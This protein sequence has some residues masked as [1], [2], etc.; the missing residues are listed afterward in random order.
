[1]AIDQLKRPCTIVLH[2]NRVSQEDVL[3][4]A[5]VLPTGFLAFLTATGAQR[6]CLIAKTAASNPDEVSIHVS[7]AQPFGFENR[8]KGAIEVVEDYDRATAAH[9]ELSFRDE[10]LSRAD[11]WRIMQRLDGTVLHKGQRVKY[12]GSTAAAVEAIYIAEKE[13]ASAYATQARTKPIFRS[14]SARY[15]ILLQV[16]K[17]M[18]EDWIDG[19]LMYERVLTGFLPELFRR[20][21]A[22]KVRHQVSLVLFGRSIAGVEQNATKYMDFYQ[23]IAADIP[24]ARWPELVR[25]LKRT[26]NGDRLPRQVSLAAQGNMLEAMH[27]TI[28]DYANGDVDPHLNSTGASVIAVTA[29]A[30]LFETDHHLLKATTHLLMGNSI[31]VDIVALSPKPLHPVPLFSYKRHDKPEFALPHW[32]DISYWEPSRCPAYQSKWILP[33]TMASLD[34]VALPLLQVDQATVESIGASASSAYD[35]EVFASRYSQSDNKQDTNGSSS[36][37]SVQSAA[38]RKQNGQNKYGVDLLPDA[39]LPD[40]EPAPKPI[41]TTGSDVA[42]R[43][44]HALMATGR[45]ISLGPKGLAPGRGMASTTVTTEHAQQGKELS[46]ALPFASNE[47]SSGIAKQIRQSLARKSSQQS[48]ASHPDSTVVETTKPI[49]IGLGRGK[50][51]GLNDPTTVLERNVLATVSESELAEASL[52]ETPKAK[53]DPF[54]AAMKAAAEEGHWT[55]SPWVTL[56]NPCNPN[57]GNMRVAAQYRK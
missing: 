28:M 16:S 11:M 41:M 44:P 45:K 57:R 26:F 21:D 18:L 56:L 38:T 49:N 54:Y 37:A 7:L 35:E 6:L 17:E 23:V 32:V 22:L 51:A 34:N 10:H 1:M 50:D 19:K 2:D 48:L 42:K 55:S 53:R 20:W 3:C 46:Q 14:G 39:P 47:A 24:G 29:G 4:G 52:S 8:T 33:K 13:V 27:M 15:T 5:N 25:K 43:P 36:N 40:R 12:L 31:G 9:V 30:G